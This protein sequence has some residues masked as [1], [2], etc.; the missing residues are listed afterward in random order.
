MELSIDVWLQNQN[1]G[2]GHP[3]MI[4]SIVGVLEFPLRQKI[5]KEKKRADQNPGDH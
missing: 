5:W 2:G 3:G 1:L 4:V